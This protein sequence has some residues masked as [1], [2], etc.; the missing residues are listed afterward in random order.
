MFDY[1]KEIRCPNTEGKNV[2][3]DRDFLKLRKQ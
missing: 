3:K 1:V 2:V